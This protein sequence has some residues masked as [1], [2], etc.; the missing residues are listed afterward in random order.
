MSSR[1]KISLILAWC[2]FAICVPYLA[3]AVFFAD[4]KPDDRLETFHAR[5]PKIEALSL[6]SSHTRDLHFP[7]MGLSGYSFA[8]DGGDLRIAEYKLRRLVDRL[9]NLTHVFIAVGPGMLSYDRILGIPGEFPSDY[10]LYSPSVTSMS[11]LRSRDIVWALRAGLLSV[12]STALEANRRSREAFRRL[13]RGGNDGGS[14][15][16]LVCEFPDN[17]PDHPHEDGI[18][19]GFARTPID[20]SCLTDAFDEKDVDRRM[21]TIRRVLDTEPRTPAINAGHLRSMANLLKE[22]GA[23]LV[24]V[25]SP[26][27]RGYFE[28]PRMKE[29][30]SI[31]RP[32][33]EEVAEADNVRMVDV[34]DLFFDMDYRTD[35]K[36]FSDPDHLSYQG[37]VEFSGAVRSELFAEGAEGQ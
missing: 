31:E 13:V 12:R 11:R 1:N 23:E 26:T 30:W 3:L 8:D 34:H 20:A 14:D 33:L 25:V 9:P 5:A 18:L 32:M 19:D 21:R 22:T 28:D 16:G 7:S 10:I 37:A 27:T 29:L 15:D 24:I 17:P 35:N 4:R 36:W 2:G 6:G